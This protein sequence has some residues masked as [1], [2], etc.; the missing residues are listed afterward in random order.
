MISAGSEAEEEHSKTLGNKPGAF[1]CA[2][3]KDIDKIFEST[4]IDTSTQTR[5]VTSHIVALRVLSKRLRFRYPRGSGHNVFV[6]TNLR[7]FFWRK[8]EC[9]GIGNGR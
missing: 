7:L 3:Q 6:L 5:A 1:F 9:Q 4:I 2:Q 8:S